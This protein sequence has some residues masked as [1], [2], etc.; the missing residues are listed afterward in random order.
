MGTKPEATYAQGNGLNMLALLENFHFLR[1]LW[2]ATMLP[3]LVLGVLF[4]RHRGREASWS[5][6]VSPELLSHLISEESI[7]QSRSIVP[8]LFLAWCVGAVAA[9]G[10]SWRQL[11][12]PV[13]QKQ[14]ALVLL[15]DLSYS[16]LATDLQPSR[17]DR[18]RRKLLD[19]LQTRDEGLTA[20]IAYA[21]D[22]HIVAPLTDDNP[23]IANLLPALTPQMMPLPGSNALDAVQQ[24]IALL[25]SA[26]VRQGRL[27][28]VTDGVSPEDATQI[29]D[30]LA[31]Q[32]RE[33]IVLGVGTEVGAPI[34]LPDGGFLKDQGGNIVVPA[35]DERALSS[36]ASDANGSYI[37]MR[38]DDADITALSNT[39]RVL[40]DDDTIALDREADQWEDMAHWFAIPLLLGC[41]VSFRRGWVYVLL[42]VSLS[43]VPAE[44]SMALE[45]DDLWK[46][47]DQQ[48]QTALQDGDPNAATRLFEAPAWRGTAAFESGNYDAAVQAF[49]QDES[50]DGW[51]N[52][53]NAFAGSGRLD[54]ALQAYRKSLE[55]DPD[56]EDAKKNAELIE[57]MQQQQE[58]Q[59]DDQP[60]QDDG[61]QGQS[62]N[63]PQQQ[64]GNSGERNEEQEQ[65]ENPDQQPGEN[66]QGENQN[67]NSQEENQSM[68]DEEQAE[69]PNQEPMPQPQ[70][71]NSAMQEDL[72]KDQAMQQWLR[73]VPDDPSG[74]LRE[75]FRYESR[76][77]QRQGNTRDSKQIW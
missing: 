26:G 32:P 5:N 47:R 66:Q 46:T 14:D 45:W 74:L 75:K 15:M 60:N 48:G 8:V 25:D 30:L 71:D 1:P 3:A 56:R 7:K 20:L 61:E 19:L 69:A 29:G 58:Q 50:A 11:P 23:T 33:L 42:P 51:Y 4:W 16:M 40:D 54:E 18:V 34:A 64:S 21:G 73:R 59:Q 65:Q 35:L 63:G 43:L 70:I 52:R 37:A 67:Q 57:K 27:L 55:L 12:Q 72:E 44:K 53:G 22:A 36:L 10:P 2:L 77:R 9:S 39:G 49:S 38:V 6:V 62:Q 31:G 28:L 76:Q 68:G 24:A 41:L 17:H 13:L